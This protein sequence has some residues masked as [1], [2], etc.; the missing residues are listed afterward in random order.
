MLIAALYS[1]HDA[2]ACLAQDGEILV[3]IEKERYTRVK[4]AG[5]NAE[6]CLR[7]CLEEIGADFSDVDVVVSSVLVHSTDPTYMIPLYSMDGTYTPIGHDYQHTDG[8]YLKQKTLWSQ[9]QVKLFGQMKPCYLVHHHIA[10][11]AVAFY[12]S[13]FDE[14]TIW[15]PDGGGDD[16]SAVLAYGHG[17]QIDVLDWT[18]NY[19]LGAAWSKF[20]EHN[21]GWKRRSYYDG[22]VSWSEGRIG[23]LKQYGGHY[24]G[25]LMALAAY[26]KPKFEGEVYKQIVRGNYARGFR[27]S[28]DLTDKRSKLSQ[29]VASSLQKA[30]ERVFIENVKRLHKKYKTNNLCICGGCAYN[31]VANTLVVEKTPVKNVYAPPIS[32]DAGLCVGMALYCYYQIFDN[33]RRGPYDTYSP[34]RGRGFS[35]EQIEDSLKHHADRLTW[36]P[37]D[38]DEVADLLVSQKVIGFLQGRG[39]T[40]K[41]ALGNRSV[42]ADPRYPE[43]KDKLNQMVKHREWFRPFA[44]TILD[45]Y[46]DEYFT[47]HVLSPY[48][49]F[50]VTVRKDK[51][52]LVPAILHV[53]NTARPQAVRREIN[54]TF[55][56]LIDKFRQRTGLPMILN[57]SF[58][59]REPIVDTPEDAINCFL[60]TNMDHL[61]LQGLLVWRK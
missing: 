55:Y 49:S 18:R 36:R 35:D 14:A 10:H 40:G 60:N 19:A 45:E 41:R 28:L 6:E 4:E 38:L 47:P 50:A 29:D 44:P 61:Y 42:L 15:T 31:C 23:N 43:I 7:L 21:Y 48:M 25:T 3:H 24:A 17:N 9:H 59:D 37:V 30:T 5:G 53:D 2:A 56:D 33:P 27:N 26:G 34:F 20:C 54:P 46:F 57:T 13:P 8:T 1:G 16:A 58:N 12:T 52:P 22:D 51:R 32:E 39:E 11:A